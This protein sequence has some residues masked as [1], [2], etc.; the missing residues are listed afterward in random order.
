[1]IDETSWYFRSFKSSLRTIQTLE[2][3]SLLISMCMCY[4]F[5]QRLC[6]RDAYIIFNFSFL[7]A[8]NCPQSRS[9]CFLLRD[10]QKVCHAR[11]NTVHNER[12]KT[13][14]IWLFI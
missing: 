12:V 13:N 4:T 10:E 3:T 14:L 1:M 2:Y 7:L 8:S 5:G 6:A 9:I 11:S